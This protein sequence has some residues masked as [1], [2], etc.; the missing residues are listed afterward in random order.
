M[1]FKVEYYYKNKNKSFL[2]ERPVNFLIKNF[3]CLILL[4]Y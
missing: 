2:S 3:N 4:F 1:S